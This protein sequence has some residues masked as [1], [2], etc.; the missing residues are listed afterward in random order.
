MLAL[1]LF[2]ELAFGT[3]SK[4]VNGLNTNVEQ[5][6]IRDNANM[7]PD[8]ALRQL[9]FQKQI[10]FFRRLSMIRLE[11][12]RSKDRYIEIIFVRT[13][14]NAMKRK[15]IMIQ[16]IIQVRAIHVGDSLCWWLPCWWL[17]CWWSLCWWLY[18]GDWFEMLV[19]ESLSWW[20]FSLC[21]RLSQCI[22]SVTN[23]A[24]LSPTHL[25]SN[26]DVTS[27]SFWGIWNAAIHNTSPP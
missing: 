21:C 20:L 1:I 6:R 13:I 2:V 9:Y 8:W 26:I 18:D 19:A 24:N 11:H 3:C 22:K 25:V 5:Q 16:M 27:H 17:P 10:K 7:P 14:M 23:I 15:C 4:L 12:Q